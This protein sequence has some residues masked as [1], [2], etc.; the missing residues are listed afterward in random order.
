MGGSNHNF[1]LPLVSSSFLSPTCLIMPDRGIYSSLQH[2]ELRDFTASET[3]HAWSYY[4]PLLWLQPITSERL[5]ML[6]PTLKMVSA[7]D[8]VAD[9]FYSY[10]IKSLSG[11]STLW[12]SQTVTPLSILC[13]HKNIKKRHYEKMMREVE[14]SS[15]TPLVFDLYNRYSLN[16]GPILFYKCLASMLADKQK[17]QQWTG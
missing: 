14:H 8:I 13:H 17:K 3:C 11:Y 2:N 12:P 1:C 7:F 9:G 10:I 16:L 15:F 6:L 5:Y 4:W